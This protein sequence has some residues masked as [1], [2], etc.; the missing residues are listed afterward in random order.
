MPFFR[1]LLTWEE[2][3][4][5]ESQSDIA[6]FECTIPVFTLD[7]CLWGQL[8]LD[9]RISDGVFLV[10]VRSP[11]IGLKMKPAEAKG[12]ILVNTREDAF[13]RVGVVLP[14]E[15]AGLE[16]KPVAIEQRIEFV[17]G[18]GCGP[19]GADE[20]KIAFGE[21]RLNGSHVERLQQLRL[22]QLADSRDFMPR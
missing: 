18:E 10:G 21:A 9:E 11:P 5:K 16:I 19:A 7:A 17:E 15:T 14:G 8:H 1:I 4:R 12:K 13:S 2:F 20:E 3:F 22:E 6:A